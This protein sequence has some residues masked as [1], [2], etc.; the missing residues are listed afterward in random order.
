MNRASGTYDETKMAW[1]NAQWMKRLSVS[2]LAER[3]LPFVQAQHPAAVMD[4]RFL[5]LTALL[6]P[7][8]ADLVAFA[9]AAAFVYVTPTEYDEK[10]CSKWMKAGSRAPFVDLLDAFE[11]LSTFDVV[12]IEQAFEAVIARHEIGMGKL[13]QPVRIALTGTA[14]SPSIYETVELVG[15]AEV[16]AR[17][18]AALHLLPDPA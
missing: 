11:G 1:V 6:Q 3:A 9:E 14:M 4:D 10:A 8:A 16:V 2:E 17:M 5:G 15:Q 7:R 18:Q 13:A 12:H